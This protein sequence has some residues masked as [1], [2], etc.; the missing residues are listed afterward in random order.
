LIGIRK[1]FV[2]MSYEAYRDSSLA[3][4]TKQ[5]HYGYN[6]AEHYKSKAVP[7]YQTTAFELGSFERCKRLFSFREEGHSYVRYSNPTNEVLEKRIAALEGGAAAVSMSSGMSAISN[8]FFNLAQQG[9][10]IAAVKTIYG[11]TTT[12]LSKVLPPYGIKTNWV[13]NADDPDSYRAAITDKTKAVYVESLGNP[14]MNVIDL[15]TVASIAHEHGIPLVVDNTFA[16]PYL[17]RPFEFG[18][19]IVVHSSTKYLSGHGTII[20]GLVV[21]K[22]G[23]DWWNGKFP[24]FEEFYKDYTGKIDEKS[25]RNTAFTRRLRI[26]YLTE[27]GSSLSPIGAFLVLQGLETLSLRM[28]RHADNALKLAKFLKNH[29]KILDVAYPSLPGSPY[30]GLA[31]KYFPRGSG[32][33][34][35]VR[36]KGGLEAAKRVFRKVRIFDYL[37]NVG[38]AK[39]LIVHPATSTHYGLP[40]DVKEKAGVYD[41]TLRISVGIENIDDLIR[42][43]AQALE[44]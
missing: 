25:L 3:F 2:A 38:D 44:D 21:E 30:Y 31:Q 7:I 40:E 12:L 28:Q 35:N 1:E 23:F 26:R 9:D 8:T 15:E 24:Q 29:P 16:T 17:L 20:S 37:V 18:A 22:G 6:P 5:L 36:V 43:M 33:I 11:G 42:D 10:E 13:E 41:D 19:D 27:F 32:A 34:L 14:G 39:S 4:E